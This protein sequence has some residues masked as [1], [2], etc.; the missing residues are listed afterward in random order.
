MPYIDEAARKHFSLSEFPSPGNAGELNFVITRIIDDYFH[1]NGARYQQAN[2]IIGA[3]EGAKLEFYRRVVGP[4]E[5]KKILEHGDV[6][7]PMAPMKQIEASNMSDP[8]TLTIRQ[9]QNNQPW[10]LPLSIDA[11]TSGKLWVPHIWGTHA[12]LHAAKSVGKLAAVF[13]ALDHN[14]QEVSNED[15]TNI[16]A[17]A[18]DL[19]TISLRFANL[20]GFDLAEVLIGRVIEK[21]GKDFG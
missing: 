5:N 4:Y 11:E 20:Y 16:A 12:V 15:V 2:D 18:A 19:T 21:N 1:E 7:L 3:L 6:Y 8:K 10:V 13:E 9:A 17:M 14:A